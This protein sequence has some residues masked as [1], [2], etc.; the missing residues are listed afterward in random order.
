MISQEEHEKDCGLKVVK[1][2]CESL[3]VLPI[4]LSSKKKNH[5]QALS[6][7][8]FSFF[9]HSVLDTRSTTTVSQSSVR[10]TVNV[11]HA[12]NRHSITWPQCPLTVPVSEKSLVK[13]VVI[14]IKVLLVQP[15]LQFSFFLYESISDMYAGVSLWLKHSNS[16]YYFSCWLSFCTSNHA[17]PL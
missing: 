13:Y 6:L 2:R 5:K 3:I 9:I 17:F 11:W 15:Y 7:F 16:V 8:P 12:S 14:Q 10:D 1:S 4:T